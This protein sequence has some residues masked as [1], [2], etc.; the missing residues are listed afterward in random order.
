MDQQQ[1]DS[2][3]W[4]VVKTKVKQESLARDNLERQNFVTYLPYIAVRKRVRNQWQNINEPLF[5]GY[6]FIHVDLQLDNVAPIRSTIG[7]SGL[8]RFGMQITPLPDEIIDYIRA[9]EANNH[10]KPLPSVPFQPGDK[11]KVLAGPFAGLEAVFQ[12]TQSRARAL[13]LIHVLGGVNPVA[14]PLDDI[15]NLGQ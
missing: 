11:V 7:V 9:Q 3:R 4:Y 14:V 12:M 13:L 2:P 8:V 10:E 6:L 1:P 5:P 15:G